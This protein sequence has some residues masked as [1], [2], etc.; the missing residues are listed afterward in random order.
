[1]G[2][3]KIFIGLVIIFIFS[4]KAFTQEE[5]E[6]YYFEYNRIKYFAPAGPISNA[7]SKILK[8]NSYITID[9]NIG[10]VI[11]LTYSSDGPNKSIYEIKN[12]SE[13]Q[14]NKGNGQFFIL[15]CRASNH[16]KVLIELSYSGE[17]IKRTIP[18]NG[19]YHKY[20]SI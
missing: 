13:L 2:K 8:Y 3:K 12:I 6:P 9:L 4:L 16:A 19:I 14:T 1:M 18:H 7:E 10:Q 17:W 20:Y 11:I 5:T 15:D